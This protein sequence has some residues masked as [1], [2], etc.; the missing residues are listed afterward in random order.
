VLRSISET[1]ELP[2]VN[3][4]TDGFMALAL[5]RYRRE[6]QRIFDAGYTIPFV[7]ARGQDAI[8]DSVEGIFILDDIPGMLSRKSYLEFRVRQSPTATLW[9]P[10]RGNGIS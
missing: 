1:A 2:E 5:H 8:G 9:R 7:T 4:S 3:P 10:R 6:R